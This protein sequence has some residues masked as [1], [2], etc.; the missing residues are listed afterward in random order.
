[1]IKQKGQT[2]LCFLVGIAAS[3]LIV[4][5]TSSRVN[6][7]AIQN[8]AGGVQS[9][10]STQNLNTQNPN[11]ESSS[12]GLQRSSSQ[13]FSSQSGSQSLG[14][15]A[16]PNLISPSAT[17]PAPT[18]ADKP[19]TPGADQSFLF[20]VAIA[21]F[22]VALIGILILRKGG[23]LIEAPVYEAQDFEALNE[24]NIEVKKS[25]KSKKKRRKPHQR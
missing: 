5:S 7:Q 25:K 22:V 10:V 2:H 14:L 17:T 9:G 18:S 23:K 12:N 13:P 1:M 4:C 3:I 20:F 6:A 21:S 15:G 19:K 8:P 16:D 11:S 24:L